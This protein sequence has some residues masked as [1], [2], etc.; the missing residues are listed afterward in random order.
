[1][2]LKIKPTKE[3]SPESEELSQEAAISEIW[4]EV[5]ITATA[6]GTTGLGSLGE[7]GRCQG[8]QQPLCPEAEPCH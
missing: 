8:A 2:L 5:N 1:M 4:E 6:T 3:Q 7:V